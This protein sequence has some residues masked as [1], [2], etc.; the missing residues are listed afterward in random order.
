MQELPAVWEDQRFSEN[1]SIL[2]IF[3]LK[4]ELIQRFVS[5][6]FAILF[7][8]RNIL[9]TVQLESQMNDFFSINKSSY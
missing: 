2:N 7:L 6:K 9:E 5:M 8:W 4:L 3:F 1:C